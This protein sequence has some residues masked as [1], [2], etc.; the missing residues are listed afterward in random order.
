MS[1]DDGAL[2]LTQGQVD[3]LHEAMR[4]VAQVAETMD[5][6]AATCETCGQSRRHNW[7]EWQ[8]RTKLDGV[9]GKLSNLLDSEWYRRGNQKPKDDGDE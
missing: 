3:H 9:Y 4:L 8:V 5:G 1:D 6:S 7:R 2:C